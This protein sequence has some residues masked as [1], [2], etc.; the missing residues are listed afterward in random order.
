M[1]RIRP[2][3]SALLLGSSSLIALSS[4]GVANAQVVQAGQEGPATEAR[5]A[6]DRDVVVV[7]ARRVEERAEDV[8]ISLTAFGQEDLRE[9]GIANA[10][11]LQ[12]FTPSLTVLGHV[13]RNQED[14]TLRGMGGNGGP[15]TGSGPGV[16][17]YFAEV[18]NTASGPGVFYDLQSLQVLKG[19]QGTL[20][21]RNSTGGAVLIEPKHPDLDEF[22]GYYEHTLGSLNR[23]SGNG[24][25]NVPIIPGELAFRLA[26]QF[27]KRDGY[28]R[29][30]VTGREYLNRDNWSL[31]AGLEWQPSDSFKNYTAV[32]YKSIDENGGGTTLIA[33]NPAKT[34]G[35]LLTPLLAAQQARS[36]RDVSLSVDTLDIGRSLLVLNSTEWKA[37]NDITLKNIISYGERKSNTASDSDSS[38]LA[39]SDLHGA[40][41][42]Q[43]NINQR[44]FTEELQLR[45]QND[46]LNVQTGLFYLKDTTP[47]NSLTFRTTNVMQAPLGIATTPIIVPVSPFIF[48]VLSVQD[49]AE[50]HGDSKAAYA[51]ADFAITPELTAT[52]GFRWTW[53]TY[54]GHIS[55]YLPASSFANFVAQA[56]SGLQSVALQTQALA[57][58][59]CVYDAFIAVTK[60][61]LPT[62]KHPNCSYPGFDGESDGA[63]WQL[64]LDWKPSNDLLLYGVSRRGY[65]SGGINP[66]VIILS[67]LGENDPLF[68]FKP[69]KV[70]DLEVG[71]K[72]QWSLASDVDLTTNLSAFYSWYDD[73]QVVQRQVFVGSDVATNAQKAHVLGLEFE[74]RLHI[75]DAFTLGATYSYN[76][77]KY[78]EW[79]T[80]PTFT[81][82]SQDF[83]STPFLYVPKNKYSIDATYNVPLSGSLGDLAFKAM[84][85]WQDEQR[86]APDA[87]PFDTIPSYGLLGFRIEWSEVAGQPVDLAVFGSNVTDEVYQVTAN[88]AYNTSGWTGAIYGE[89]E[90]YGV[91]ARVHF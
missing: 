43:Y 57:S 10:T 83:S 87:Q 25:I 62:L 1:N 39:I 66:V 18:P 56:P 46:W 3:A 79:N 71:M 9:K 28:S 74:G 47:N 51:Q 53:D 68:P 80:L 89:P 32:S 13:S 44:T 19:P 2:I 12:N 81:T 24:A 65:K 23:N 59:L 4:L 75:A 64:G 26:G 17:A 54:G 48:P 85:S 73:I 82:P 11:D 52:A 40:F 14:F 37:T 49:K 15:G 31:R 29:D 22:S 88:P 55:A 67:P 84:W 58:D 38:R 21:G 20:F 30:V 35:P 91:S 78:D 36:V 69:E 16:V 27:D 60:G 76:E 41:P 63:T 33:V 72:R 42:G 77:A 8:P 61:Q 7:T 86:V 45:Y 50:A 70:T 5:S 34:Y 6:D 90:Q